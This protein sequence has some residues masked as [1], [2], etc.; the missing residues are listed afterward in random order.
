MPVRRDEQ[1]EEPR[2]HLAVVPA[3]EQPELPIPAPA[4]AQLPSI[5]LVRTDA[6]MAEVAFVD[7]SPAS[8]G[9]TQPQAA[10]PVP[11]LPA[12]TPPADPFASIMALSEE[13][14]L[15]LFT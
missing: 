10:T 13:E 8:T 1:A 11:V 9:N 7:A 2:A 3:P 15:A 6:V 14:R 5:A 4:S 12:K